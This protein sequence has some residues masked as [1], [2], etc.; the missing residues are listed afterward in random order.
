MAGRAATVGHARP[1]SPPSWFHPV[2]LAGPVLAATTIL[3]PEAQRLCALVA[4]IVLG[5]PHGALDGEIARALLWPR[6]GWAWFAVFALPYLSLSAVV[7]LAWHAAP[8]GTLAAFLA[9][10]AWHFGSEDAPGTR[11]DAVIRGG[12][13]IAAPLLVHPAATWS[14]FATVAEVTEP[15]M[16]SWLRAAALAWLALAAAW[17]G[18]AALRGHLRLLRVP[19]LLAG[20]FIALPPLT[21]FAIYFVCV[22]APSHTAALIRNPLRA[23][24]VRDA[25]SAI[26]LAAP[27][28]A[29][30]LLIGAGLWPLYAGAP[31][32]RLLS[33]TL[34]G[35]A[36]LTLPHMLLDA[37]A[38]AHPAPWPARGA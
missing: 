18:R 10:S 36:A 21:A 27:I 38:T 14:V 28:T 37:W 31:A 15:H 4:V 9:A 32:D 3:P 20:V 12:L 1:F 33:L 13:P 6:F 23:P 8:M 34:Q 29:L 11:L 2:L 7:L 22:H 5:V 16:P 24:R 25:R 17:A 26:A 35:L 30:T 19:A